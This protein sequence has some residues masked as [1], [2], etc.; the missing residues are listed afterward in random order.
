MLPLPLRRLRCPRDTA[1]FSGCCTS[2][3]PVRLQDYSLRLARSVILR[4]FLL[5]RILL[6]LLRACPLS[7]TGSQSCGRNTRAR[8]RAAAEAG[9]AVSS[10]LPSR[11]RDRGCCSNPALKSS[12]SMNPTGALSTSLLRRRRGWNRCVMEC[13]RLCRH[14]LFFLGPSALVKGIGI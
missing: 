4:A 9:K 12:A 7:F 10:A 8:F 11:R 2:S 14:G 1:M 6:L 13:W 3:A 5:R